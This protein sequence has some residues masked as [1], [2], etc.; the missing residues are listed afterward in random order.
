MKKIFLISIIFLELSFSQL[1]LGSFQAEKEIFLEDNI[2]T[3]IYVWTS[4]EKGILV[5][6]LSYYSNEV[7]VIIFP[8]DFKISKDPEK[9]VNLLIGNQFV[10]AFPIEITFKK[11]KDFDKINVTVKL[12]A[13]SLEEGSIQVFQE[14]EFI[15]FLYSNNTLTNSNKSEKEVIEKILKEITNINLLDLVIIS[16]ILIL[17]L[18]IFKKFF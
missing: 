10:K 2:T 18:L 12:I 14:R 8:K 15:Y 16:L 11:K 7:E 9:Y 17:T 13:R 3:Y 4:N 1:N 6:L 5:S